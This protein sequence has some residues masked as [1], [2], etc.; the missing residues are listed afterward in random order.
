MGPFARIKFFHTNT[1]PMIL[2]P[3]PLKVKDFVKGLVE[4]YTISQ[5]ILIPS[6]WECGGRSSD[7]NVHNEATFVSWVGI[8][9]CLICVSSKRS[10]NVI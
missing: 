6:S 1:P 4:N 8:G 7:R 5:S 2:S 3:I 10:F 9:G